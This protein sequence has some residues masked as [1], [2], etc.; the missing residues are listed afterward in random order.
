LLDELDAL[1]IPDVK[2]FNFFSALGVLQTAI[3][4]HTVNVQDQELDVRQTRT[5]IIRQGAGH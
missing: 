3:G 5:Y 2:F 4:E 1:A